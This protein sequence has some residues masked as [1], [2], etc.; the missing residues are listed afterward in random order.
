MPGTQTGNIAPANTATNL[1]VPFTDGNLTRTSNVLF[2]VN[3]LAFST[4]ETVTFR[5][6]KEAIADHAMDLKV[7]P[8]VG[9]TYL[10]IDTVKG[11][12][13]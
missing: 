5:V 4:R 2:A 8:H 13:P 9:A 6:T 10:A 7:D 11:P 3:E 12:L 1:K